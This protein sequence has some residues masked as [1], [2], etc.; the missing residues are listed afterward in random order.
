LG[1]FVHVEF[2]LLVPALIICGW[3]TLNH[4]GKK[5][6]W[7]I[8]VIATSMIGRQQYSNGSNCSTFPEYQAFLNELSAPKLSSLSTKWND[9][10]N[11][12]T[13]GG[14]YSPQNIM[15]PLPDNAI[16]LEIQKVGIGLI[17]LFISISL[18]IGVAKI[19]KSLV[20]QSNP[21]KNLSQFS[22]IL[23][24]P[25]LTGLLILGGSIALVALDPTHTFYRSSAAVVVGS[26]AASQSTDITHKNIKFWNYL[27]AIALSIMLGGL[28]FSITMWS[29]INKQ[30]EMGYAGPSVSQRDWKSANRRPLSKTI[31][32]FIASNPSEAVVIDDTTYNIAKDNYKKLIPV[33]YLS[34]AMDAGADLR[35]QRIL[36]GQPLT[37]IVLCHGNEKI[38]AK[39]EIGKELKYYDEALKK[40]ICMGGIKSTIE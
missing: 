10:S 13:I 39:L 12:M 5:F 33:T 24:D 22:Q 16:S 1:T 19:F 6:I 25:S 32:D 2:I 18:F 30:F 35:L 11:N 3:Q 27:K 20:S 15:P 8:L 34:L 17:W 26:F 29:T 23:M 14:N 4:I 38:L 7:V 28:F 31:H 40:D 21:Y 9:F 37:A 36:Q